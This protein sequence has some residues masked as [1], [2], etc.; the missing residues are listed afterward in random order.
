MSK[1]EKKKKGTN[2]VQTATIE[3]SFVLRAYLLIKWYKN[4]GK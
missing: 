2:V 1:L 4:I 3:L